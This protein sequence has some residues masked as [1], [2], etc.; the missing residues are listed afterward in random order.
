MENY[1]KC[2]NQKEAEY[3]EKYF[4]KYGKK[5][6][7]WYVS[8]KDMDEKNYPMIFWF[9]ESQN[10]IEYNHISFFIQNNIR[11]KIIEAQSII[12]KEKLNRINK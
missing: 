12:R 2:N 4:L 1:I 6:I 3:V 11:Y 5:L 8:I 9:S 10:R 7:T